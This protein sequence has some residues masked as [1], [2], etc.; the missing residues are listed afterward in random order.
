MRGPRSALGFGDALRERGFWA[1]LARAGYM[2]GQPIVVLAADAPWEQAE[3]LTSDSSYPML[4][5][6][7][8]GAAP[9][10]WELR[11]VGEQPP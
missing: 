8:C 1:R 6:R 3:L 10:G 11:T 7:R 9:Y 2:P 4:L 5:A